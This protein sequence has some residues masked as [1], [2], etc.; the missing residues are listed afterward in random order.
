MFSIYT[1]KVLCM[2]TYEEYV[3]YITFRLLIHTVFYFRK[4]SFSTLTY[5][6]A[7]LITD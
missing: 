2:V 3:S 7:S 5:T 6:A 1:Q 4:I